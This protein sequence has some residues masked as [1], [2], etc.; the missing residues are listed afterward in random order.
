MGVSNVSAGKPK[1]GGAVYVAPAGTALPADA[2]TALDKAYKALGYCSDDGLENE[3]SPE[4][5]KIKAWGGNIV[6]ILNT[7]RG[8]TFKFSLLEVLDENVLKTVYGSA[9]VS[10]TLADGLVVKA[11]NSAQESSV[12]VFELIMRDNA[13]K[14]IVVPLGVLSELETITYKDDEAVSYG[15]TVDAMPDATENTHYE[16]I[17]RATA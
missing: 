9:N 5:E 8:D 2:T 14:R 10:G 17:K 4:A 16:Y 13:V 6:L 15:I 1:I 7:E 11:N 12:F 3:N